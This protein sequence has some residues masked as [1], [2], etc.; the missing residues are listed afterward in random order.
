MTD[1]WEN[2]PELGG[3]LPST[4]AFLTPGK[5]TSFFDS[6]IFVEDPIFSPRAENDKFKNQF[7]ANIVSATSSL[8]HLGSKPPS[9]TE[10]GFPP[11]LQLTIES[12]LGAFPH[13]SARLK[14]AD[15]NPTFIPAKFVSASHKQT[16]TQNNVDESTSRLPVLRLQNSLLSHEHPL[17]SSMVSPRSAPTPPAQRELDPESSNLSLPPSEW[18]QGQL[19]PRPDRCIS[20]P[21]LPPSSS[22]IPTNMAPGVLAGSYL[23][24]GSGISMTPG[25]Y[26]SCPVYQNQLYTELRNSPVPPSTLRPSDLYHFNVSSMPSPGGV[27]GTIRLPDNQGANGVGGGGAE[28]GGASHA[29]TSLNNLKTLNDNRSN[30]YDSEMNSNVYHQSYHMSSTKH[31][32]ISNG[33]MNMTASNP[34]N[35]MRNSSI[36]HI[37]NTPYL[38]TIATT[39]STVTGSPSQIR[40]QV[41]ALESQNS[42]LRRR[43]SNFESALED[44]QQ[45]HILQ[46][47]KQ[48][49]QLQSQASQIQVQA[50]QIQNQALEIEELERN[51]QL[52]ERQLRQESRDGKTAESDLKQRLI[53]MEGQLE[54][55]KDELAQQ[56]RMTTAAEAEVRRIQEELERAM[57]A[58]E[59][60]AAQA[61][62]WQDEAAH[63]KHELENA[64][65]KIQHLGDEERKA[66]LEIQSLRREQQVLLES[67]ARSRV[68]GADLRDKAASARAE[69]ARAAAQVQ[70]LVSRTGVEQASNAAQVLSLRNRIVE[71]ESRVSYLQRELS[72]ER[73]GTA[74]IVEELRMVRILADQKPAGMSSELWTSNPV[75]TAAAN[76][77][78]HVTFVDAPMVANGKNGGSISAQNSISKNNNNNSNSTSK[79]YNINNNDNSYGQLLLPPGSEGR[80]RLKKGSAEE[81]RGGG[82]GKGSILHHNNRDVNPRLQQPQQQMGMTR[83]NG[84]NAYASKAGVNRTTAST[85]NPYT[86][87]NPSNN[88]YSHPITFTSP[89]SSPQKAVAA[90]EHSYYD[91]SNLSSSMS[92]LDI[93]DIHYSKLDPES[94]YKLV[95]AAAAA[96]AA[97]EDSRHD[98]LLRDERGNGGGGGGGEGKRYQDKGQTNEED[99]NR[100]F[101]NSQYPPNFNLSTAASNSLSL[102]N[103][104]Y[105]PSSLPY[106]SSYYKSDSLMENTDL[107]YGS[108][109]IR[110]NFSTGGLEMYDTYG[111]RDVAWP[112]SSKASAYDY[113]AESHTPYKT[114]PSPREKLLANLESRPNNVSLR[115]SYPPPP[116]TSSTSP[117]RTNGGRGGGGGGNGNTSDFTPFGTEMSVKEQLARTKVL[118]DLLVS[119]CSEKNLLEA[120]LSK[121]PSHS[122]RSVREK[123][124]KAQ[125]EGR[126]EELAKEISSLRTQI[127]KITKL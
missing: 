78:H 39:T 55:K 83:N 16:D 5:A 73:E 27:D 51:L 34:P 42:D 9:S 23:P 116:P 50:N 92:N 117:A 49:S 36:S 26:G 57:K 96:K 109:G 87:A 68:D 107:E 59:A 28:S 15:H 58:A 19:T 46:I 70:A 14:H 94:F 101:S 69:A 118:E 111:T 40:N 98:H 99:R 45:R 112:A 97:V 17:R 8:L 63:F 121:L 56:R 35:Q 115:S 44:Q 74:R 102:V 125:V 4:S 38:S 32:P 62:S 31:N 91:A 79:N 13:S 2:E 93:G 30:S 41:V 122:G 3:D 67:A 72:S 120:E 37:N 60:A 61:A 77:D 126:L 123:Q 108:G 81:G 105:E 127:K 25:Q 85:D 110:G 106:S 95:R 10:N 21:P 76:L 52:Q 119:R 65:R 64:T 124:R 24:N 1:S 22:I 11:G 89:A 84:A 90:K 82:G 43:I 12:S 48:S 66:S 20:Y 6:P 29:D 33:T 114:P 47:Q 54:G 71:L 18:S 103:D 88:P 75:L 100:I 104:P 113:F 86:S 80:E 53:E 7:N